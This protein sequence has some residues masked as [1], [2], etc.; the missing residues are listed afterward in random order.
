MTSKNKLT[1]VT[2]GKDQSLAIPSAAVKV[3]YFPLYCI[4]EWHVCLTV[5]IPSP[6]MV[7]LNIT[8]LRKEQIWKTKGQFLVTVY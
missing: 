8:H 5:V 3:K 7:L 4:T 6:E 2:W 1:Y